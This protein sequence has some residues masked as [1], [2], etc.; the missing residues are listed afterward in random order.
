MPAENAPKMQRGR[1][2]PKGVSG[3]PAGK[4]RGTRHHAT[5]AAEALLDGEAEQL[6]RAAID[7]A[8][9]GD[10]TALRLCLDRLIPPRRER[11]VSFPMPQLS[12]AADATK[13]MAAIAQAVGNGE[14]TP[15]EAAE[16]ARLVETYVKALETTDLEA[17]LEALEERVP[18]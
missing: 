16:L 4:P 18:K 15:G 1:P 10:L 2:W 5:R 3:N 11:V 14:L 9:G 13:V 6:T 12:S 7:L 8:L 17:R